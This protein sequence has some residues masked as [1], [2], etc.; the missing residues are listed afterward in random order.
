MIFALHKLIVTP[1]PAP[2][3]QTPSSSADA[4]AP[5]LLTET[6]QQNTEVRIGL[7]K[8]SDKVDK[9]LERVRFIKVYCSLTAAAVLVSYL[10]GYKQL[11]S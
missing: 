4:L 11:K 2:T 6:R 5:V 10:T 1:S 9:I 7:S 8:M 3:P